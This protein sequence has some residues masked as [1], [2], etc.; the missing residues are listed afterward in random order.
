M[1]HNTL[2]DAA[3]LAAVCLSSAFLSAPAL[4][5]DQH[6]D[7]KLVGTNDLQSRSSYQ[8]TIHKQGGR[9][10]AYVGHHNVGTNP[11]TG[12][13][14]P[15]FNPLTGV[16]ERNGTSLL[17]VTDPKNPVYLAHIPVNVGTGGAQM[18][19]VCDGSVLPHGEAGKVYMLR[20]HSN[21][22]HEIWDTTDPSHPLP[23]RTFG[24]GNPAVGGLAGTHKNWWD[25]ASGI[26][27]TVGR[28][29][30][31]TAAGWQPGN[32]IQVYDMSDPK[33]PVFLRNWALEGMQPGGVMPPHFTT[34]PGVHGPI[35]KGNRLY[36][37]Y[38]TEENGVM[39]IVD[40]PT[41]L[42]SAPTDFTTAE[43]GR[44][45]M[46][47]DQGG[48][49][50]FPLGRITVPD[51][52]VNEE[53]ATR[54][55]VMVVSEETNNQCTGPRNLSYVVDTTD[56]GRPMGVANFQVRE[57]SGNF[58]DVGGRFGPHSTN[59]EFGAPFYQKIVFIAYFNAGVRAVDI[60]DPLRPTEVG[61]FIP[62]ITANTDFRCA[63]IEGVRSCKRAIQTNNV[64]TDDRGFVYIVDRANTGLHVLELSGDAQKIIK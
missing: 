21:N 28:N 4:A 46:T 20:N 1:S 19:R 8:P 31:D 25:C 2:R 9:Y 37:A 18:V 36:V 61:F 5:G 17:D 6:K 41:L 44:W 10:I 53:G 14:L 42:G 16:N 60:R 33:N 48:H 47:D 45:V 35:Q 7:M 39:Q 27:Y 22:A 64:A 32:Y 51:F 56:E 30:T 13:P 24:G 62:E 55:Y 50:S 26:A 63:T 29:A 23:V 43:V 11:V 34:M 12:D 59:E 52:A 38:G 49:T 57:S 40:I 3:K 15:S 54:D 58:C